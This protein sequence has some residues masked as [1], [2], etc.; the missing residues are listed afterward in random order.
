MSSR[1][2]S[3]DNVH[4]LLSARRLAGRFPFDVVFINWLR[5]SLVVTC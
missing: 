3:R 5:W 2:V 1:V 4:A